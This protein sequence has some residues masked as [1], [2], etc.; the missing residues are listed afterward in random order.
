VFI[1]TQTATF[2][3]GNPTDP[4][5]SKKKK[6]QA[7]EIFITNIIPEIFVFVRRDNVFLLKLCYIFRTSL[8]LRKVKGPT[9][10]EGANLKLLLN[11]TF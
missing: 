8:T 6:L 4:L 10:S 1:A 2:K 7:T 9:S 3:I 5:W 11:T